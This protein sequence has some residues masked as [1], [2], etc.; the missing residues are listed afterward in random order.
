MQDTIT[1]YFY[2]AE[3]T[4][5]RD[6]FLDQ[7]H[8]MLFMVAHYDFYALDQYI[9][10]DVFGLIN[11]NLEQ[12][13]V[14]TCE[15]DTK[16]NLAV[17]LLRMVK[18]HNKHVFERYCVPIFE[19]KTYLQGVCHEECELVPLITSFIDNQFPLNGIQNRRSFDQLP[20]LL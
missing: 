3:V 19:T 6:E 14:V 2:L 9:I 13:R 18:N 17:V 16:R 20:I 15:L 10:C 8:L 4:I 7:V 12:V 11:Q 1:G 5:K